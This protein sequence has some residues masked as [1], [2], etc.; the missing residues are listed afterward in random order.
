MLIFTEIEFIFL[1]LAIC[2]L[3]PEGKTEFE[4]LEICFRHQSCLQLC[5]M[6]FSKKDQLD[7]HENLKYSLKTHNSEG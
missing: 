7:N 1:K 3:H 2:F 5:L 6:R 4:V